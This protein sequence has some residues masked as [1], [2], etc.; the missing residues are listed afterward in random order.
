M[1]TV[2]AQIST[3]SNG[4]GTVRSSSDMINL[5]GSCGLMTLSNMTI[6]TNTTYTECEIVADP[7]VTIDAGEV[8]FEANTVTLGSNVEITPGTVFEVRLLTQ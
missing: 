3:G 5:N 1:K 7:N 2:Y 8:I 4:S 6:N